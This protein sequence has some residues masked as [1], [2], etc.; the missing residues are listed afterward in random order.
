MEGFGITSGR[1]VF[2]FS[3]IAYLERNKPPKNFKRPELFHSTLVTG[4]ELAP[5]TPV[6]GLE[7]APLTRSVDWN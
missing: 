1:R 7:L 6:I 4:P 2:I 3:N 5:P